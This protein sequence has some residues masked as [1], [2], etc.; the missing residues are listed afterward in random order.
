MKV[1]DEL[2]ELEQLQQVGHDGSHG[3]QHQPADDHHATHGAKD[4]HARTRLQRFAYSGAMLPQPKDLERICKGLATLDAVISED[5]E[6]RTYSFNAGWNTRAKHRMASMRNG[7]GD[8]WFI[9]FTPS[10]VFVKAFWHEYPRV[11]DVAALYEGLPKALAPQLK[12][13][14]FEMEYV[15]FGGWHDGKT[16]TLRGDQKPMREELVML[17][18]SA[19]AY[20]KLV[21]HVYE[22]KVPKEVVT[23]VLAGKKLD[24]AMLAK[25]PTERTLAELRADLREIGV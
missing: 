18:G 4:E 8:D 2:P 25:L 6:S 12:E 5:W 11:D 14:A 9:V 22:L 23:Q 24:A 20:V 7:S 3:D 19:T 17:S 21:K 1:D 13:A 16:W 10:G 15:T